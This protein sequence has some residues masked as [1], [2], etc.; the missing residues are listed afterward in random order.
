VSK[1]AYLRLTHDPYLSIINLRIVNSRSVSL[2]TLRTLIE[3]VLVE[4]VIEVVAE[5][6]AELDGWTRQ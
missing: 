1:L 2:L 4:I 6:V 3:E 5:V